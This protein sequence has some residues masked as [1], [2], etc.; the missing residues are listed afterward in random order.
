MTDDEIARLSAA[1]AHDHDV[2]LLLMLLLHTGC[3]VSTAMRVRPED[4]A[5]SSL[6]LYNVKRDRPYAHAIPVHD[7]A[8]IA[9]IGRGYEGSP[10]KAYSRLK[11]RMYGLFPHDIHGERLSPHSIRHTWATRALQAGVPLD[12]ISRMLDHSSI[13]ITLAVYARHSQEQLASAA[14]AVDATLPQKG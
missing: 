7:P 2:M 6:T 5:G 8:L 12:V 3:R 1:C 10:E 9:L 13:S 14:R 11:S 4:L